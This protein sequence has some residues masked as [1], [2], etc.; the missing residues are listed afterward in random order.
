MRKGGFL[1]LLGATIVLLVLALVSLRLGERTVTQ[2]SAGERTLPDLAG[3]LGDLTWIRLSRGATRV[4]FAQIGGSWAVVEKGN[5]PAIQSKV[6]QLL[7]G[8]AD[9]TLVE[10]K[11]RRPELLSRLALDDPSKGNAT[12]VTLQDRTGNTVGELIVGKRRSDRFGTGNDGVYVRRPGNDQAWLARG[13]LDPSGDALSWIDRH[14]IDLPQNRIAAMKFTDPDGTEL[15]LTRKTPDAKF[16]AE[17]APEDINL[18][19]EA[20]LTGPASA[21][22]NFDFD[23]LK[24][25][26]ELPVPD[27]GVAT[28]S[29]TTFDGMTVELFVFENGDAPWVGV[30]ASGSGAGEA[31]AKTIANKATRWTFAIP[32]AKAKLLRSKLGDITEPPKGS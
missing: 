12:Q 5:Y 22:T 31:E 25:V 7:L 24:P 14:L 19:T 6:R 20:I 8:L 4:N 27:H 3:K 16:A 17:N 32:V 1:L 13:S 18:K 9:V 15:V 10:P 29:Y 30:D 2:A 26:T 11:T 28:A 23:D 21:L